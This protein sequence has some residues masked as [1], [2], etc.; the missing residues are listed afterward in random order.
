[1]NNCVLIAVNNDLLYL[2]AE[3]TLSF[4]L[5]WQSQLLLLLISVHEPHTDVDADE[6]FQ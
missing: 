1:V 6:Y 4:V 5:I 3:R 2:Y